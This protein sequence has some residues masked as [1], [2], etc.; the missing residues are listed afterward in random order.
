M[1][2]TTTSNNI[3]ITAAVAPGDLVLF[4]RNNHKSVY[5]AA[6]VQAG[7]R[8]VYLET[9]R[10]PY[11]FIGG[12]YSKDFDEKSIR[13]KIAKVDPEKLRLRDHSDWLLFN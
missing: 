8:P 13:E 9:S 7:G 4:D 10:D 6:L 1:N 3:A 12:I 2:G 11:G 5:N